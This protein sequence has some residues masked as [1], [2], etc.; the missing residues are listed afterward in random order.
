MRHAG[1]LSALLLTAALMCAMPGLV[2]LP[3]DSTRIDQRLRPAELRTLTVWLMPGDVG[4][5]KLLNGLCAAFEKENDGVRIFL[6]VVTADELTGESAVLP[7]VALFETGDIAVPDQVFLPLNGAFGQDASGMHAGVRRAVPLWLAPNVLSVP[8]SWLQSG[9]AQHTARPESL[10]AA[11]TAVPQPDDRAVLRPD[12]LPWAQMVR[13]GAVETPSG[14]GLQ[15]LLADCPQ[16]LRVLLISS[17]SGQSVPQPAPSPSTELW[18]TSLPKSAGAS[19]TPMP[20]LSGTARLETLSA[21]QTRLQKGEALSACVPS[22]AVS[23]RVRYAALCRDCKDAQAFVQFLLSHGATALQ[24][25]LI[26]PGCEADAADVLTQALVQAY[27]RCALPN[28]FAHTRQ[29]LLALCEDGFKRNQEPVET[30][31]RLR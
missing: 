15:Q 23:N 8:A 30:L 26:P 3:A 16:Q 13:S 10:L 24:H 19:P 21:H 2:R 20:P 31:L 29:E 28:A 11:A 7:D 12:E 9:A 25:G 17:A 27:A 5:R 1:T 6:R 22:L 18:S 14:V 4:D